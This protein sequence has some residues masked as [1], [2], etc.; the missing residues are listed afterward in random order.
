MADVKQCPICKEDI[1]YP[2]PVTFLYGGTPAHVA[3]TEED[4]TDYEGL[5]DRIGW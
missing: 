2:Q 3:C 5:A 4:D 1:I